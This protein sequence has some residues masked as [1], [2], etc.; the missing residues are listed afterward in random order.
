MSQDYPI[1]VKR[2]FNAPRQLV[3]DVWTKPEH[4]EKWWGPL[5]FTTKVEFLEFS[6]GGKWKYVMTGPDG[7]EY[8]VTGVFQEIVPIEKYVST[9]DFANEYKENAHGMDIPKILNVTTLFVDLGE[10]TEVEVIF[11]HPTEEDRAKHQKMGID[12]GWDSS[13]VKMDE[14]LDTIQ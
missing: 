7:T 9:D 10:K 11:T 1:T 14:Y 2:V 5:G 12:K 3:W 13:F 8:P 4:I 6:V